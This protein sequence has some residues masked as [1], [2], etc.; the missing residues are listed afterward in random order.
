MDIVG[1]R[2]PVRGK[3]VTEGLD[4]DDIGLVERIRAHDT[5]AFDTLVKK[6][7]GRLYSVIYNLTSNRDDAFDLTQDVLIKMF[8]SIDKFNGRSAF[9]TWLYRIAVNTTIS[10]IRK[11]KL[12]RFFSFE[13][14]QEEGIEEAYI[15][16]FLLDKQR[17]DRSIF[18]KELQENLNI[19]LQ[20]LSNRHR[21]VIVLYEIEGLDHGEIASVLGCSVGTVRSRLHY[22]KEQLKVF[23]KDYV[24]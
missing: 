7:R 5:A 23:L 10:F 8:Q 9:F 4:S 21:V 15:D 11:N 6:Y 17:G 12:R 19:A 16:N 3:Q 14:M 20:K 22:A 13:K 2:C 18:L 24:E 1:S